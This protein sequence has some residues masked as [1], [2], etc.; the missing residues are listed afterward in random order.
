MG[1][2]SNMFEDQSLLVRQHY[3][4]EDKRHEFYAALNDGFDQTQHMYR[5]DKV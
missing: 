2:I 5:Q 3:V 1:L 4:Q